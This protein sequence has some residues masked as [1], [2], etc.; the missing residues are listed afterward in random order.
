M[1]RFAC[2]GCRESTEEEFETIVVVAKSCPDE[3]SSSVEWPMASLSSSG[4]KV[5]LIKDALPSTS[6]YLDQADDTKETLIDRA[7]SLHSRITFM[8]RKSR[9]TSLRKGGTIVFPP[10]VS[11]VREGHAEII[12]TSAV[13]PLNLAAANAVRQ[14]QQRELLGIPAAIEPVYTRTS[15]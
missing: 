10:H 3:H 6:Y 12:E 2:H 11:T 7:N 14:F 8:L 5:K 13:E 1:G 9:L 15:G 4:S